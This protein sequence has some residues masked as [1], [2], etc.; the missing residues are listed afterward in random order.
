[1]TSRSIRRAV[2]WL[3]CLLSAGQGTA[4]HPA[5]QDYSRLN[6]FSGFL[7]YSNDSSHIILGTVSSRKIGALGFQYQRRLFQRRYL[8]FSYQ[9]EIRPAMVESD[10]LASYTFIETAPVAETIPVESAIPVS[11]CFAGRRG[12]FTDQLFGDTYYIGVA[13]SRRTVVEQG[14]TPGGIRINLAPRHRLQPTFSSDAG[15]VF[16][17]QPVPVSTAGSFNFCFDFGGGLE[18]FY[19]GKRSVRLEY[20]VQHLS[21]KNTADENP[22]IDSG[23]VRITYAFGR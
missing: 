12:P 21:N 17:T 22:G 16:S 3:I 6:T 8:D 19:S 14:F 7:E 5:E 4:Q 15:Y 2:V 10:P 20:Q 23:F 11:K 9:A 1:M 13:C 18:W